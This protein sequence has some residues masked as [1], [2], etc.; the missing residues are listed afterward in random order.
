MAGYPEYPRPYRRPRPEREEARQAERS[1]AAVPVAVIVVGVGLYFGTDSLF[2]PAALGFLLLASGV[3]FLSTR[4]NPLSPHFYLTRKPSWLAIGVVFLGAL[5]LL[6]EAY[7]L[8]TSG[9][10]ARLLP[11]L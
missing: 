9:G 4:M 3:S 10:A 1:N 6:G 7:V 8:W 2:I 11:H 5:A